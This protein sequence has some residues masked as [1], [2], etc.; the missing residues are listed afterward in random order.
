MATFILRAAA[1]LL[2]LASPAAAKQVERVVSPGGIEAWLVRD[3]T[4]PILSLEFSFRGGSA[5]DPAGKGGLAEITA[6]MMTEGAG[7]L[8]SLAFQ[9]E[10]ENRSIRLDFDAGLDTFQGRIKALDEHRDRAADMLRLALTRPR[11]D[12]ADIERVRARRIAAVVAA[13]NNPNNIA[14]RTWWETAFPDHPYGRDTRGSEDSLKSIGP[15]D[16]RA[17]IAS[18]LARDNLY[19]GAVGDISPDE[20]GRLLDRAFDGLPPRAANSGVTEI[21]PQGA[22]RVIVKR[23]GVP[24]SV[25]YF[26]QPGMKRNDPDYYA[27]LVVNYVLGG[28]GLTS[29]LTTEVRE[30]RGLAYGIFSGLVPLDNAAAVIGSTATQNSRAAQSIEITRTVWRQFGVE[31]PTQDELDAAKRHLTGSFA[32]GLDT[33]NQIA[34]TLV[35]MQYEK[36]G[37]DYL[38]RRNRYIESVTLADAERVARRLYDEAKLFVVVVGEPEGLASREPGE[39]TKG[40]G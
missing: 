13:R 16:L 38:E 3:A 10:L 24:Q 34:R 4:I 26:G 36:L 22:G 17:F 27:A 28:G 7:D 29:R 1:T 19:I 18:R 39:G 31:G 21:V 8:D 9:A 37:I 11:F 20:L 25:I 33:T 15:D 14:R 32:L 6:D 35:G 40:G 30:K 5:L 12:P 23:L 2:L